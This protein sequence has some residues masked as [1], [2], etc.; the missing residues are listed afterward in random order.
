MV[1]DKLYISANDLLADAFALA[2]SILRSGYRP[3][4]LV[5]VWRGGSPIAIA[6]EEVLRFHGVETDHMAVKTSAYSA[7]DTMKREIS[8][9]GLDYLVG[10]LTPDSRLLIVDDVFDRGHSLAALIARL[11]E[12]CGANAPADIKTA[13]IW[14]KPERRETVLE[15]DWYVHETNRWLVF[16]HELIGLSPEEIAAHKA[17]PGDFLEPGSTRPAADRK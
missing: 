3:T 6:V 12:A 1:D 16:P 5:G 8:V 13:C 15:P 14:Y 17:V 4:H 7:I 10:R 9:D 11:G 2:L